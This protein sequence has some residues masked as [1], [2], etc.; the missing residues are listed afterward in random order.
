[1]E[2]YKLLKDLPDLVGYGESYKEVRRNI[3]KQIKSIK[4]LINS[5]VRKSL[6][7]VKKKIKN[8]AEIGQWH[9]QVQEEIL[10][11]IS[12]ELRRYGKEK[13]S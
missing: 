11:I 12:Q 9:P 10:D 3:K 7:R 5:E 2:E 4:Q 8:Y 1:M 6:E 13:E